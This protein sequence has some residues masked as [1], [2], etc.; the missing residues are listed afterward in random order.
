MLAQVLAYGKDLQEIFYVIGKVLNTYK[1][2]TGSIR[3]VKCHKTLPVMAACGL[4]RFVR[5]YNLEDKKL[6]NKVRAYN[7]IY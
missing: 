2:A 1:G 3:C 4:D 7:N 6:L 5:I